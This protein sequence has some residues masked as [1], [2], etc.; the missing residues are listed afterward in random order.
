MLLGR[1][2]GFSHIAVPQWTISR[3]ISWYSSGLPSHQRTESGP[4]ISSIS[5]TQ[6]AR[7]SFRVAVAMTSIDDLLTRGA[8]MGSG[9][10]RRDRE[11]SSANSQYTPGRPMEIGLLG[12]AESRVRSSRRIQAGNQACIWRLSSSS[13]SPRM[14][15]YT[16]SLMN[17]VTRSDRVLFCRPAGR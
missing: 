8:R 6:P 14:L 15:P 5:P 1:F 13:Y 11:L 9:Q 16:S 12:G 2:S 3:S 4:S 7:S 17:P 10:R